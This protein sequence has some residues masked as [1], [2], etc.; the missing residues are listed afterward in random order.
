MDSTKPALASRTVWGALVTILATAAGLAGYA[1]TPDDQA[2]ALDLVDRVLAEWDR[3]AAIA[4]AVL[5]LWGRITATARIGPP[6]A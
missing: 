3:L 4:G 5:A 1:V 6:A 2:A